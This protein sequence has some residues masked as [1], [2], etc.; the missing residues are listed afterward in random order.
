MKNNYNNT[1]ARQQTLECY[2]IP[3]LDPSCNPKIGYLRGSE[4]DFKIFLQILITN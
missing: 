1:L 2:A 3:R 4:L